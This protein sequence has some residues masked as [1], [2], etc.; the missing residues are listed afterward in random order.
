MFHSLEA[1]WDP[2]ENVG[3]MPW[4]VL[5]PLI[6]SL[7]VQRRRGMFRLWNLVLINIAFVLSQFGMF[8][9]RGGPVVSVHSFASSTLGIVFL[10]FMIAS[11]IF[12]FGVFLVC[13]CNLV[14]FLNL[15][16][17]LILANF[18][19]HAS[20]FFEAIGQIIDYQQR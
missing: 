3:L 10:L 17:L 7:I 5:T 20:C 15:P 2:I 1:G 14:F 9:N 13:E 4:L 12:A 19:L 11:I 6:H 18:F 8:I 16:A